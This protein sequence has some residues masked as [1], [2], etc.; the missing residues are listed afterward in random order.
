V[1]ALVTTMTMTPEKSSGQYHCLIVM[2]N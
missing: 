2:S 1:V